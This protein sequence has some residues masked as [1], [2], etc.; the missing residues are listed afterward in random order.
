MLY[1][2]DCDRRNRVERAIGGNEANLTSEIDIQSGLF[3]QLQSLG[4]LTDWQLG[5]VKA[6]SRIAIVR[7]L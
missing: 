7:S 5:N 4:V 1:A 2:C 6:E 3:I